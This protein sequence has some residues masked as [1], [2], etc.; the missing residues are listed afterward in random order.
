[1]SVAALVALTVGI[2]QVVKKYIPISPKIIA[3][4]VSLLVTAFKAAESGTVFNIALLFTW[5]QVVVL[6][7]GSVD[8]ARQMFKYTRS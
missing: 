1:M 4:A 6:A 7:I 8:L 3:V 2:V 5:I